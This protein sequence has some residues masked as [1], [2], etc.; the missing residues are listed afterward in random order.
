MAGCRHKGPNA[1]FFKGLIKLAAAG[2]KQTMNQP[3]SVRSHAKRAAEL[4]HGVAETTGE[5][6][7]LG[8]DLAEMILCAEA[9]SKD[10]WEEAKKMVT[11]ES[12]RSQR[13]TI[14]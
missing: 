1:D 14:K 13:K 3:A 2:V 10:G 4:L 11:T 5:T 12:P 8:L 6:E 9:V 7:F